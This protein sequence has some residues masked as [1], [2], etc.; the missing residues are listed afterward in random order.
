MEQQATKDYEV[1]L[2]IFE[3]PLDL[4]VYLV[5]KN[6]LNPRD[7]PIAL[8]TD[9]YLVYLN[10][11]QAE[12]NLS[13]A[14]EFLV[15]ASRLMRL[16][17]RELL[18]SE[19]KDEL[20]EMEYELDKK[21]LIEQMLEYQKYKE[22]SKFL[23]NLENQNFGTLERGFSERQKEQAGLAEID[24]EAGLYDLLVAFANANRT[25]K[26]T[27]FHEVEIDD[28]TI[29][30]QMKKI[31][32]M[33]IETPH[34]H[35]EEFFMQDPQRIIIVVTFMSILELCKLD[36]ISIRQHTNFSPIWVYKRSEGQKI[37]TLVFEDNWQKENEQFKTGLVDYVQTAIL[38]RRGS[39]EL[40]IMIQ[41]LEKGTLSET[42][43]TTEIE[44]PGPA[45]PDSG[46][47]KMY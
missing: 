22:A 40:D 28:V 42:T 20:E 25:R 38:Q 6:E 45:F 21:A 5:Q 34:L 15:M 43:P 26:K 46:E 19:E 11:M 27:K 17:A 4:L 29:E 47:I 35:F 41:E 12:T 33:L 30:N 3:G 18:P 36:E 1:R 31:Q 24:T 9:Q 14:G 13:D 37:P 8:I 7:I 44:N 2:P 23:R 16:K 10:Q 39:S 32:S